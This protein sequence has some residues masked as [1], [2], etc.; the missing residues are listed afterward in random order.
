VADSL[1]ACFNNS[2]ILGVAATLSGD[3]ENIPPFFT[4]AAL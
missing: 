2:F 1:I 4:V 3:F